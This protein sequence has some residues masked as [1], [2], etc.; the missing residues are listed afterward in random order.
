MQL[1]LLVM[2]TLKSSELRIGR[3]FQLLL[4]AAAP[5]PEPSKVVNLLYLSPRSFAGCLIQPPLPSLSLQC[6]WRLFRM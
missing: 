2:A 5:A 3:L 6:L 4:P 1:R